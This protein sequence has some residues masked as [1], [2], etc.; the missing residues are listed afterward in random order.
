MGEFLL[1]ILGFSADGSHLIYVKR[2]HRAKFKVG[3]AVTISKP[4]PR[5]TLQTSYYRIYNFMYPIELLHELVRSQNPNV[6]DQNGFVSKQRE[7]DDADIVVAQSQGESI[8]SI[9]ER[10]RWHP[11]A[12]KLALVRHKARAIANANAERG[13]TLTQAPTSTSDRIKAVMDA[14][15]YDDDDVGTL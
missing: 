10:Y 3:D 2:V 6:V 1:N 8:Q 7:Y 5:R 11:E 15:G 14:F 4:N 12:V 9:A 13:A